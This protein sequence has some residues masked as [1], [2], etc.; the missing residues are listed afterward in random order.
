MR[1]RFTIHTVD[2]KRNCKDEISPQ[3]ERIVKATI[4]NYFSEECGA[5]IVASYYHEYYK[6]SDETFTRIDDDYDIMIYRPLTTIV[7]YLHSGV[8][9]K[10]RCKKA[11]N[12][13][14]LLSIGMPENPITHFNPKGYSPMPNYRLST[15]EDLGNDSTIYLNPNITLLY[16]SLILG[17]LDHFKRYNIT[18][19]SILCR[20]DTNY[21]PQA[22]PITK[23]KELTLTRWMKNET[24]F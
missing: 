4:N 13:V 7:E 12:Q 16:D 19:I 22:L 20:N 15:T 23:G 8:R 17:S 6:K 21:I 10:L 11:K 18:I 1:L 24:A 14:F 5:G 2:D 3:D 9:S